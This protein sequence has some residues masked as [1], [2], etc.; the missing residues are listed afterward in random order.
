[1]KKRAGFT[2]I[3]LMIV[4]AI[5]AILAVSGLAAYTGYIKKARDT[6][7]ITD[8]A[9]INKALLATITQTGQSPT[10]IADVIIAIKAINNGVL[11]SDP[12]EGDASCLPAIATGST[13]LEACGYYYRQCDGGNGFAVGTKFGTTANQAKY[14]EDSIE[15][16]VTTDQYYTLGSC[17][18]YCTALPCVIT[19]WTVIKPS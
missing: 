18:A 7:R 14:K 16:A 8:I 12:Q 17:A 15:A 5:I 11:L 9:N 13:P 1:M 3:E 10:T 19:D 4:M 6:V 2:L